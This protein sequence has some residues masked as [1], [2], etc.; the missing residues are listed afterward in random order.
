MKKWY[1]GSLGKIG[2]AMQL[3]GDPTDHTRDQQ[4]DNSIF[5]IYENMG[6]H[7]KLLEIIGHL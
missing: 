2:G 6:N 3:Q 4:I 1:D 5:L 7:K